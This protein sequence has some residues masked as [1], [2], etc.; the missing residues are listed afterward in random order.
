MDFKAMM[1]AERA[2][3]QA[4]L[5]RDEKERRLEVA[6]LQETSSIP[7][8]VK[9]DRGVSYC[10]EFLS[11][12]EAAALVRSIEA[13]PEGEW[14]TLTKRRLLNLGGVPH[15]SGSWT[16]DLPE[17]VTRLV[18]SRLVAM[19][20]FAEAQ[21]PNQVL[22]NSYDDGAGIDAHND[23]P[24]FEPLACIVSLEGDALI[25]FYEPDT[26]SSPPLPSSVPETYSASASSETGAPSPPAP[27]VVE[28]PVRVDSLDQ[29][30]VPVCSLILR[31]N[32]CLVFSGESYERWTHAIP[33]A[34]RD[35]AEP[36]QV[37]N[38]DLANTPEPSRGAQGA[39][40]GPKTPSG[41]R[42]VISRSPRR[43][44]LTLRR[45]KKV[46]RHCGTFDVLGPEEEAERARRRAWWLSSISE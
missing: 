4:E 7:I 25:H 12:E 28:G 13:I 1:K 9:L 31:R 40:M 41:E 19:G 5:L 17:D 39:E 33:D 32:S 14:A 27:V 26:E 46:D 35:C 8:L 24:L 29:P 3:L 22:L 6:S 42:V 23:G 44:S 15:P 20:V 45:L 34:M 21:P 38:Y 37:L 18:T 30:K 43:L 2:R 11:S 16:E 36:L 10:N